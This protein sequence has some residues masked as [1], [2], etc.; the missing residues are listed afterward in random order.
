MRDTRF[1]N[2]TGDQGHL[3]NTVL[4]TICIEAKNSVGFLRQTFQCCHTI[5]LFIALRDGL[6]M[7]ISD[8]GRC[9]SIE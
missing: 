5:Q 2:A 7:A 6:S 4:K 8:T 1:K 9:I 3:M